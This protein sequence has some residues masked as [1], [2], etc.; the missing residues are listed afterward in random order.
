[1]K[2]IQLPKEITSAIEDGGYQTP[3][4]QILWMLSLVEELNPKKIIELGT[5][6]GLTTASFAFAYPDA[7]VTTVDKYAFYP[8]SKEALWKK[9]GVE[10]RIQS[11]TEDA[12]HFLK[13]KESES[14][15]F[16]Y[17]DA[18]KKSLDIYTKEALR[19]L[20]F[21][22][23]IV[24]DNIFLQGRFG[25]EVRRQGLKAVELLK[26]FLAEQE[27]LFEI[28]DKFDGMLILYK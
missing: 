28:V 8:G 21:G 6:K 5:Y 10:N 9:L 19:V 13:N 1:M 26:C 16:I 2:E 27:I 11:I 18:D 20:K 7:T 25:E 12:L 24:V 15:D 17:V 22:G 4:D 14:A 3:L 23:I